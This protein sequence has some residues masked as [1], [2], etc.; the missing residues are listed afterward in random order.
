LHILAGMRHSK[1]PNASRSGSRIPF[2]DIPDLDPHKMDAD[3]QPNW[4]EISFSY[5]TK[6]SVVFSL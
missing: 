3:L 1:T 5:K 4:N 2:F 6:T